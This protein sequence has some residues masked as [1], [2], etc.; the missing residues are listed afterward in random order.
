MTRRAADSFVNM[1]TVIKKHIVGQHVDPGPL[2]GLAV[3]KTGTDRLK[4]RAI[5]PD[6]RMAR[7]ACFCGG[8]TGK[9]GRLDRRMAVAAVDPIVADMVLV[10]EGD[11]LLSRDINLGD[12]VRIVQRNQYPADHAQDED[13]P[14]NTHP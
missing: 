9:F 4:H 3:T 11:R 1:Y 8:K 13:P 2:N 12:I 5:D 7:H 10:A 14:K 6:L